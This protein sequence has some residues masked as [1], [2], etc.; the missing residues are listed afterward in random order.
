MSKSRR[1][2]YINAE[3]IENGVKI[4]R[5]ETV[6]MPLKLRDSPFIELSEVLVMPA[7]KS[8]RDLE[9]FP[10]KRHER[11]KRVAFVK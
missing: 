9:L 8:Y 4:Q 1:N 7:G 11:A 2:S 6:G 3:W 5:L 10:K